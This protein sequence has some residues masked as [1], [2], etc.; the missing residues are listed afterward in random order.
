MYT[1]ANCPEVLEQTLRYYDWNRSR[2]DSKIAGQTFETFIWE[3]TFQHLF[4][5]FVFV[6]LKWLWRKSSCE[7]IYDDDDGDGHNIDGDDDEADGENWEE[8]KLLTPCLRSLP[9]VSR[10]LR[11]TRQYRHMSQIHAE[12]KNTNTENMQLVIN[13][14]YKYCKFAFCHE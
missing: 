14:K 12:I 10:L 5:V 7:D 9:L 2:T 6:C 4:D 3:V 13:P 1:A 8:W 11:C